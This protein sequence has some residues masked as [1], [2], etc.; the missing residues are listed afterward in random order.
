MTKLRTICLMVIVVALFSFSQ[1]SHPFGEVKYPEGYPDW[2][3][4]KTAIIG[5]KSPAFEHW[6]GFHHIYANDKAVEG[7]KRNNFPNGSVLVFDVIEAIEKNA[8]FSE[9]KRRII[10]VMVKDSVEFAETGGWVLR[11]SRK[12]V[13]PRGLLRIWLR[14]NVSPVILQIKATTLFLAR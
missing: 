1:L 12:I 14:R 6:G 2:K 9:G 10:D 4:I 13:R 7:N 11:N 5:P 3:H 8:D